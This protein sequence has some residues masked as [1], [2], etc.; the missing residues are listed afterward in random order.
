MAKILHPDGTVELLFGNEVGERLSKIQ[1]QGLLG[2]DT[3]IYTLD[4]KITDGYNCLLG[5]LPTEKSC[6]GPLNNLATAILKLNDKRDMI[7]G[8]SILCQRDSQGRYY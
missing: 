4:P 7:F 5:S 8:N 1:T 6:F 2:Y 3:I